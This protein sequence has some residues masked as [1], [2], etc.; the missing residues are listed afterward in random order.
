[1]KS[2]LKSILGSFFKVFFPILYGNG[3]M[4]IILMYHR[5]IE[6]MPDDNFYDSGMYVSV[7][8][9]K[10]HIEQ[11]KRYFKIVSLK[12]LVNTKRLDKGNLCAITFDDGWYDNYKFAFPI[13]KDNKVPSSIFLPVNYVGSDIDFWF[14]I[15]W[16][17]VQYASR[18]KV[19]NEFLAELSSFLPMQRKEKNVKNLIVSLKRL[20]PTKLEKIVN[21]VSEKYAVRQS[22][23]RNSLSWDE[24]KEMESK[25]VEFGSHGMNHYILTG[26]DRAQKK[27]EIVNSYNI[28]SKKLCNF[29]PYF[30]YPDGQWDN[31]CV[32]MI[33]SAGYAGAITTRLGPVRRNQNPYLM[34]RIGMHNDI[35]FSNGLFWYRILQALKKNWMKAS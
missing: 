27:S 16:D 4:R 26:L 6:K 20:P 30:C 11:I 1:M 13:L 28:L 18:K 9:L 32:E 33:R 2:S 8:T 29:L 31:E 3:K 5:V 19:L 17:A 15:Y 14:Q 24:V 7:R 22:I 23:I 12:E 35:S 21:H 10:R 34:N 25:G